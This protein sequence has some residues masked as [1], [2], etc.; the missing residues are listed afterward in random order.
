MYCNTQNLPTCF[1]FPR[2]PSPLHTNSARKN[3]A[4]QH[5]K[6]P[7][8]IGRHSRNGSCFCFHQLNMRNGCW[9]FHSIIHVHTM[10]HASCIMYIYTSLHPGIVRQVK[11]KMAAEAE[12]EREVYTQRASMAEEAKERACEDRD[13]LQVS[14]VVANSL[15]ALRARSMTPCFPFNRSR[16]LVVGFHLMIPVRLIAN[17]QIIVVVGPGCL[18]YSARY[19]VRSALTRPMWSSWWFVGLVDSVEGSR[20]CLSWVMTVFFPLLF[21]TWHAT[22]RSLVG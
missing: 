21:W 5:L 9:R 17:V 15:N 12:Q 14:N 13:H 6:R 16:R 2:Y 11:A 18:T 10:H 4:I 8:K 7:R 1:L 19:S 22:C 3:T 20:V